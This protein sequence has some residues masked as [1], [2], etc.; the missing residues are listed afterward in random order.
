[1]KP[2]QPKAKCAARRSTDGQP[3][4]NWPVPG[5]TV[6][7]YH[8]G[9]A[10]Q[11]AGKAA[12]RQVEAQA[13]QVLARLGVDPVEDV[14]TAL[15]GLAGEVL[16]WKDAMAGKVN[17]LTALRYEASGAGTEQLRAE[18]ALWERALDR[19]AEVLGL[20]AR[21]NIDERLAR[22]TAQQVEILGR[23]VDAALDDGGVTGGQAV[24][25]RV[26]LTRHLRAVP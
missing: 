7:R 9:R 24:A 19:C 5:A 16:A 14:F 25:V 23:A 13:R 11:V 26:A 22:I 15:A 21:C 4:G 10:P 17:E 20:I 2:V 6:C 8:G 3:C 12:G 18:V 1:M